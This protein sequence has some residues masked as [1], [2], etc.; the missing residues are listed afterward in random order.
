[1]S[2][3]VRDYPWQALERLGREE[4][5]VCRSARRALQGSVSFSRWARAVG[6]VLGADVEAVFHGVE[7]AER[8]PRR[9][10]SLYFQTDPGGVRL[11]F[12][13]TP[14]LGSVL[15][16]RLLG[17]PWR[18]ARADAPLEAVVQGALAA[19][20]I[21]SAR[22]VGTDAALSSVDAWAAPRV[23]VAE[24]TL[25]IDGSPYSLMAWC[26]PPLFS[27]KSGASSAGRPRSLE[28]LGWLPLTLQ[29]VIGSSVCARETLALLAPG[30]AWIPGEPMWVTPSEAQVGFA[31]FAALSAAASDQGVKVHFLPDGGLRLS[32][33]PVALPLDA[34]S[35]APRAD[36]GLD[37]AT[38]TGERAFR[39]ASAAASGQVGRENQA[40]PQERPNTT[41]MST[42]SR[43]AEL[44]MEV[45][46]TEDK[47][48]SHAAL[49]APL[50]VRVELGSVSLSAREWAALEAGD[51][52]ETGQRVS[53]PVVLRCAGREVARGELVEVEG[54]VG[55]RI[56]EL[57]G[58][59]SPSSRGGTA[60]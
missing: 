26:D 42:A 21:E 55:V 58:A 8:E 49:D 45:P 36:R 59:A 46:M 53:E 38:P 22:R 50:V 16:S 27:A 20:L 35:P 13:S 3:N 7:L 15:V 33:E 47:P 51:V 11:G 6:E 1:M 40:L 37:D 19:L 29:L 17:A 39:A 23:L 32:A 5:Q 52:I 24:L 44:A 54:Q 31:G 14:E 48:L 30:D 9:G 2:P 18:L 25:L 4:I 41:T 60:T 57:V 56:T 10:I 34:E 28:S 43:V 12:S